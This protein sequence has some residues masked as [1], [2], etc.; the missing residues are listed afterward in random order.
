M[1]SFESKGSFSKTEALL[2][3]LSSAQ[4]YSRLSAYGQEGVNALAAATPVDTGLTSQGWSYE[5]ITGKSYSIV[6]RNSAMVNG[7]P[8]VI[9]LQYG[10]GTGTGGFV[11]GR[12]FIN[13]TIQPLFDRIAADVWKVVTSS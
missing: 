2:A 10:H 6:W 7:V 4:M 5:V 12:D 8:L 11:A 1:I 9:L 3:K 13:S